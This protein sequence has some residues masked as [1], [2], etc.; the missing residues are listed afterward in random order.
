[1]YLNCRTYFS[2]RY[3]TYSTEE[4]VNT[5]ADHGIHVL[6]LTNINCT[7]DSWDFVNFCQQKD[8]KPV[9][10][11]EIRNEDT[12]LYLL[13][14]KNNQGFASINEF[15]SYHLQQKKN[16]PEQAAEYFQNSHDVYIIYPFDRKAAVDLL[17]DEYLG[18]LA[19]E[20]NKLFGTDWKKYEH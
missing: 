2:L 10:G 9:A 3:G 20:L 19:S 13:L 15:L 7:C 1:M 5:A 16:F 8:I 6:A 12:L 17:P 11:V 14:A 4:L 18:I